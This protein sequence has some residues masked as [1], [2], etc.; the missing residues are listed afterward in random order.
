[1]SALTAQAAPTLPIPAPPIPIS[2]VPY[3]ITGPGTYQLVRNLTYSGS[4]SAITISNLTGPVVLDFKGFTITGPGIINNAESIGTGIT[5]QGSGGG[6]NDFIT[7]PVTIRNGTVSQFQVGVYATNLNNF[8]VTN[9]SFPLTYP[10]RS[11][12]TGIH[13]FFV[14]DSLIKDC[15]IHD[16]LYGIYDDRSRGGNRYINVFLGGDNP[17][18][19]PDYS[20]ALMVKY[21]EFEDLDLKNPDVLK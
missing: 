16:A 19:V 6:L 12:A 10:G 18:D 15:D 1:M 11:D 3:N 5:V 9:M 20:H 17:L 21:C 13:L 2:A 4:G 7:I 14:S 8:T